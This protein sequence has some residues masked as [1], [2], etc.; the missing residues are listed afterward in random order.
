[1]TTSSSNWLTFLKIRRRPF[2]RRFFFFAKVMQWTG[3]CYCG[4][5]RFEVDDTENVRTVLCHCR[6]C[7]VAHS[8][9][10]YKC[11][12]LP[13]DCV[14]IVHGEDLLAY[15]QGRNERLQRWFCK[16]CGTRVYNALRKGDV[17][18]RGLFTS[19]FDKEREL[20][21]AWAPKYHVWCSEAVLP[22]SLFADGLPKNSHNST[23]PLNTL[24]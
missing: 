21:P 4:A 16:M 24:M 18:E 22:L 10:L 9:P 20:P 2:P 7:R 14:R 19:L 1:M 17:Q 11:S 5:V 15:H 12:Y 8:A 23:H 13:A 3:R 6:D